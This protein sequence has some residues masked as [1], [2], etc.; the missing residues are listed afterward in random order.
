[1]SRNVICWCFTV[2]NPQEPIVFLEDKFKYLVYQLEA[3]DNGTPHYQ[4]YVEMKKRT[5]LPQMKKMFPN[6]YVEKKRT[7]QAEARQYCMKEEGRL[8][9]PWEYGVFRMMVEDKLREVIEDMKMTGK[10]PRDYME[11]CVN[12]IDRSFDTLQMYYAEEMKKKMIAGF[13]SEEREWE[14]EVRRLIDEGNPRHIIW[15]YGPQG[16]EGKTCFAKKLIK[17]RDAFYTVGGKASD[18]A[19]L[20]DYEDIVVFDIPRDKEEYC[21]YGLIEQFKNGI[22]QS[23]KYKPVMKHKDPPPSVIVFANFTPRSGMLSE[24]RICNC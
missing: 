2:N 6:A 22:I 23:T 8:Q 14:A 1:M 21:N 9:G 16:G 18:V 7:S 12:T 24:D 15:V 11:D 3:G 10:R 19:Y 17:E 20:Y 5:S 4:G 13:H